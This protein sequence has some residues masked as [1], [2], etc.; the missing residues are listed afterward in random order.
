[1]DTEDKDNTDIVANLYNPLWVYDLFPLDQSDWNRMPFE[2]TESQASETGN[3]SEEPQQDSDNDNEN[4][5]EDG[6]DSENDPNDLEPSESDDD[7]QEPSDS[8]EDSEPDDNGDDTEN[9][10]DENEEQSSPQPAYALSEPK[11]HDE[12]NIP[13]LTI[14]VTPN[15]TTE[16]FREFQSWDEFVLCASDQSRYT[17]KCE[18][19]SIE[20][21]PGKYGHDWFRTPNM[22]AAVDMALYSGWP[23]G[24]QLLS[25]FVT[26][27]MPQQRNFNVWQFDVAGAFP[28]VPMYCAGDP[29]SMINDP[30]TDLR[31]QYPVIQIDYD[32]WINNTVS[33]EDMMIRGA[34]VLSLAQTLEDH[35]FQVELRIVS[36][37]YNNRGPKTIHFSYSV[38]FKK[39]GEYLDI[40]RAAFAMCH[41]SSFRRL[42]FA[43]YEQH[44][45]LEYPF[46]HY[47]YQLGRPMQKPAFQTIYITGTTGDETPEKARKTVEDAAA[48]T[49]NT[50]T[51]A[52]AAD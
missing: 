25:E 21:E 45:E 52:E 46:N 33:M 22:K 7:E 15:G 36:N 18:H 40:D 44:P 19:A 42:G 6:S 51:I 43:L 48:Q 28:V 16:Y 47:G 8:N 2:G 35:G 1:M 4:E 20:R 37:S 17:W 38:V 5:T 14:A 31:N 32:H 11:D 26:N 41:A 39:P 24:R 50:I 49:L 30:G 23:D 27:I 10:D 12:P 29:L 34:A 3:E 9:Q 13:G